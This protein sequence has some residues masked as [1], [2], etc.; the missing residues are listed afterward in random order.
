VLGEART[1]RTGRATLLEAGALARLASWTIRRWGAPG[2]ERGAQEAV[3]IGEVV[4]G[5]ADRHAG[6]GDPPSRPGEPA[7]GD[8]LPASRIAPDTASHPPQRGTFF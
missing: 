3:P 5:I 8:D 6:A 2:A 1:S 4:V 7:L